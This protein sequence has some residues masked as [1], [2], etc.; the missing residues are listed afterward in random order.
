MTKEQEENEKSLEK[1]TRGDANKPRNKEN[2]SLL[3]LEDTFRN[4][5]DDAAY[6]VGSLVYN[7]EEELTP[8]EV[9]ET[10]IEAH[11]AY[12]EKEYAVFHRRKGVQPACRWT[13]DVAF[14]SALNKKDAEERFYEY[15]PNKHLTDEE[16]EWWGVEERVEKIMTRDELLA[17]VPDRDINKVRNESLTSLAIAHKQGH[18]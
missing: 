10:G 6:A 17:I 5:S 18:F 12:H 7:S 4:L 14:V 2:M 11:K 1:D 16:Y 15:D 3:F 13:D 9:I 8:R